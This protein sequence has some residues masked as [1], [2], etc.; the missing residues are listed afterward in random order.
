[1]S[2]NTEKIREIVV[3]HLEVDAE[4]VVESANFTNLGADSLDCVELIMAIEEEFGFEVP[5]HDVATVLTVGDAVEL[6]AKY[7]RRRR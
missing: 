1:M 2:D 4:M 3:K 6:V 7:A 5:G